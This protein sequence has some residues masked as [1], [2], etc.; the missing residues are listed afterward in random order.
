MYQH[1]HNN[2]RRAEAPNEVFRLTHPMYNRSSNADTL[3]TPEAA[4]KTQRKTME[5]EK[6]SQHN[7]TSRLKS[8]ITG[9]EAGQYR[10]EINM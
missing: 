7:R 6:H 1:V 4:K 10:S 2:T 3:A 8:R 5:F 9:S